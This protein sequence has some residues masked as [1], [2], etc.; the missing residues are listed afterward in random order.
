MARTISIG[1]QGFEDVRTRGNFYV[2]KTG[3]IRDWW[4]SDDQV[5]LICR[6]RRF[7]KTLNL[8]TV[9]C[10]LST[11]FA[12]RGE[13]LF[14]GLQVWEDQAMRALQGS[15]PVVSL[16]FARV[17]EPTLAG[18]LSSMKRI[19][20][21]TMETHRYL[22]ESSAIT[23]DDR[24]FLNSISDDMPN[25]VAADSLNQLC[26]MLLAHWG[27]RPVVLLDEYDAPMQEAWLHGFWDG[28]ATFQRSLFNATFKTNEALG[29]A[30]ITGVT[31]V[32]RESIFSDLNN[33]RVVTT[34]TSAYQTCFGFTEAEVFAALDEYGY[35]K[36]EEVRAWYDGFTFGGVSSI[37]NPWSITCML[38][39]RDIRLWWANTSGNGLVS[40]LVRTGDVAIKEDFEALLAGGTVTKTIDEEVVFSDLRGVPGA[41]WALL[42]ATGYL[43][44][45]GEVPYVGRPT[46]ELALTN[47]EVLWAFDGMVERWFADGSGS[48]NAFCQALVA[49]DLEAMNWYL[50]ELALSVMSS[51]DTG[52]RPSGDARPERF[53]HGLVLGLLVEMR[54]THELRSN[55]ESGYG[56]YD[57]MLVPRDAAQGVAY[58]IEFKVLNEQRG[59]R[60]LADAVASAH[61]QMEERAYDAELLERG[62]APE[63]IRHLGV[64]FKGK[65]V[66]VG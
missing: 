39:E 56:R 24:I 54:E 1:A 46:L 60:T 8:D 38:K 14:G 61:C 5:T 44:V 59:E 52:T 36:R 26:K 13:E 19:L 12:G 17:K 66:L 47:R 42:L 21:R 37:Y 50:S 7:G 49:W 6:P 35:S 10:F 20:R 23:D 64:A 3:F 18:M 48:Y 25:D 41:L 65:Q 15:V 28:A 34:T 22:R 62:V 40:E 31:R 57:V 27:V 55:R 32:S 51:F 43:R 45:A 30:L 58:I 63:R 53:W 2:D 33:L 16:S 11:D 9:R 29:R 4:L